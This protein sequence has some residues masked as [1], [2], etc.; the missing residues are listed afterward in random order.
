MTI[1]KSIDRSGQ[2]SNSKHLSKS[3][4]LNQIFIGMKEKGIGRLN[5]YLAPDEVKTEGNKTMREL[6]QI[7]KYTSSDACI[8]YPARSALPRAEQGLIHSKISYTV[9][10]LALQDGKPLFGMAI[11]FPIGTAQ[12]YDTRWAFKQGMLGF[13]DARAI[14]NEHFTLPELKRAMAEG[15]NELPL[16]KRRSKPHAL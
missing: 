4:V 11:R 7:F 10:T 14:I 5:I 1:H 9:A 12:A 6:G 2:G 16:H 13:E 3:Q 8:F 15:L